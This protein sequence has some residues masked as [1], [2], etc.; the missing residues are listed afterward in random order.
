MII[1]EIYRKKKKM[2]LG[3]IPAVTVKWRDES[4]MPKWSSVITKVNRPARMVVNDIFQDR[5]IV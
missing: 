3:C 1:A 4:I 2:L 5:I